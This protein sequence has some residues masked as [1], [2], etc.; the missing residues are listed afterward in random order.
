MFWMN[1]KLG[2]SSRGKTIYR[3]FEALGFHGGEGKIRG[4]LCCDAV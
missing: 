3:G 2:L 1:V 4:S